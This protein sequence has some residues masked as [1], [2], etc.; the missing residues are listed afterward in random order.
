[1]TALILA[2]AKA[3]ATSAPCV[4]DAVST[5]PNAT[6]RPLS[7]ATRIRVYPARTLN[8][9]LRAGDGDVVVWMMAARQRPVRAWLREERIRDR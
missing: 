7:V 9:G 2:A 5:F 6:V 1:M 3:A 4:S 8:L